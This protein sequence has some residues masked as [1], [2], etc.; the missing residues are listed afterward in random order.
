MNFFLQ[1]NRNNMNQQK[2]S[3]AIMAGGQGKRMK[4]SLPK[5][6]HRV[7]DKEMI[8]YSIEACFAL[9]NVDK[10]YIIVNPSVV[11]QCAYLLDLFP[12]CLE[13]ILQET[14]QGTG[15]AIQCLYQQKKLQDTLLVL[16]ADMPLI[17][18]FILEALLEQT[19]GKSGIIGAEL[20]NPKG[21]GRLLLKTGSL[22]LDHIEED[23]DCKDPTNQLCNM[24]VYSFLV[25]DLD[26]YLPCLDNN[27][28]SNEYYLTQIFEFIPETIVY[29]VPQKDY[30][31]LKG[32]NT[33]E[34]LKEISLLNESIRARKIIATH[35]SNKK[36]DN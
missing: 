36:E 1:K 14:P 33:P 24:G 13:F 11:D 18:T 10:I 22:E 3:I 17:Q 28:A 26:K 31:Y 35:S 21:Y 5:F 12:E 7:N 16:N 27:N 20:D 4:S 29:R 6:L 9:P 32:V 2:L 8:V 34:E 15:H 19:V 23:K 25:T 30:I